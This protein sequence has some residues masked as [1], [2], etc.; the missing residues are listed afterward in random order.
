MARCSFRRS[1]GHAP[2]TVRGDRSR[3][4]HAPSSGRPHRFTRPRDLPGS[5]RRYAGRV[6]SRRRHGLVSRRFRPRWSGYG[7]RVHLRRLPAR[8][9]SARTDTDFVS[10]RLPCQRTV[11]RRSTHGAWCGGTGRRRPLPPCR[12][13]HRP[14]TDTPISLVNFGEAVNFPLILGFVLA[15]FGV[16]TLLHLLV[17]SVARRRH[18]IGLLKALGF[19]KAQVGA[20]VCWQASTVAL[21]GIVVGIPLGIAAGQAVWRAFATNLG[22]VP[23][24][25][26]AG[27]GDSRL[28]AGRARRRQSAGRGPGCRGGSI[29]DHGTTP[30]GAVVGVVGGW[31]S[32]HRADVWGERPRR[33]EEALEGCDLPGRRRRHADRS[34]VIREVEGVRFVHALAGQGSFTSPYSVAP[35]A[36]RC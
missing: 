10:A 31:V 11:R 20:T 21:V 9:L 6:V 29:E 26:R 5:H 2:S 8:P 1:S 23:D 32:V 30:P 18:E 3:P 24:L 13:R 25:H 34:S 35:T 7:G 22:A 14:T 16:A 12:P 36:R 33:V 4:Y 15:L 27:G 19:V 17:V 28:G